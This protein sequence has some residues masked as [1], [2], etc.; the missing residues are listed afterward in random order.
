MSAHT[1]GIRTRVVAAAILLWAIPPARAAKFAAG[2]GEPN[3][4]Y[5]IATAEQLV[6]IGSDPNLLDKHFVLLNDIDLDPNLPGG[7]VFTKAPIAPS[8]G[9]YSFWQG[10][11]F[12][13]VFDGCGHSL[14]NLTFPQATGY[15]APS[16][17]ALFGSVAKGAVVS[18]LRVEGANLHRQNGHY[19]SALVAWNEGRIVRCGASG[20]V[21][22]FDSVGLLAGYNRG[23]ILGCWATGDVSG[24]VLVGGLVGFNSHGIIL[25]SHA[26]CEVLLASGRDFNYGGGLVGQNLYGQIVNCWARGDVSAHWPRIVGGLVG[27]NAGGVIANSYATGNVSAEKAGEK[28]GGLVGSNGGTIN[29]C[30]ATGNV[31]AG[32]R[33]NSL[34]GL[35]GIGGFISDSYATGRVWAGQ[36]SKNIGGLVGSGSLA[37]VESSFWDVETSGLAASGGGMGLTTAQMQEPS[38]YLAAGWDLANE[39]ANGAADLWLIPAEGGY[40]SLTVHAEEFEARKLN[41]VG[42]R[43][44]PF[45]IATVEDLDAVNHH[46]LTASYRLEVDIDLGSSMRSKPLIRYFDGRFDGAGRAIR[47]LTIRG[48]DHLGLF[49]GLGVHACVTNLSITDAN[50]TGSSFLGSLAAMNRG[51][52]V[53]CRIDGVVAGYANL[54][55]LTAWNEGDISDSYCNG[56]VSSDWPCVGGLTGWNIGRISRCYAAAHVLCPEPPVGIKDHPG[57]LVGSNREPPGSGVAFVKGLTEVTGE[58]LDCYFLIDTDGGGPDNGFG[59][60]LLDVQMKQQASFV[61]WDF[62]ST[63]T[64]C[65]GHGYPRLRWEGAACE[66]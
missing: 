56:N 29:D 59:V 43:E 2:T 57:G 42:T 1:I 53:A 20:R 23:E 47:G 12:T 15:D 61:G 44:D 30:F 6:S 7:R 45:Q 10:V 37:H 62:E 33:A 9:S 19:V 25:N 52:I 35:V 3:D 8:H 49:G 60:P 65:E 40:P 18:D 34:G 26:A 28:L 64:I 14:K 41:G 63:W 21:P 38:T 58:I 31:S 22:G 48:G 46:D 16:F 54:G 55:L 11:P 13:G 24:E 5:Q 17:V 4:P 50:V 36:Y 39:R 32:D 51:K 66:P 27:S